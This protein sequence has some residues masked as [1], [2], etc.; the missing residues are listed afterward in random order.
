MIQSGQIDTRPWISHRCE[1]KE[2]PERMEAW[3]LPESRVIKAVVSV[4][5]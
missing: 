3:L 2:L 1:F 5:E 4:G